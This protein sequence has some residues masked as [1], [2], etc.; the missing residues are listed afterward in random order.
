MNDAEEIPLRIYF[1]L[2]A[3]GKAVESENRRDMRK[4]RLAD[5]QAHAVYNPANVGINLLLHPIRKGR[6]FPRA[7]CKISNLPND[8][9]LRIPYAFCP[10]LTGNA[11]SL[12]PLKTMSELTAAA[13]V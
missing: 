11:G 13:A 7:S 10:Q 12:S 4:R 5:G 9:F 1:R 3:Q 2:A 8:C 6:S